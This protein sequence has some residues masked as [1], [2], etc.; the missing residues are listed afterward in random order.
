MV[1]PVPIQQVYSEKEAEDTQV[2]CSYSLR[3]G[4]RKNERFP[5]DD[6]QRE[7][8]VLGGI[9]RKLMGN[10]RRASQWPEIDPVL[11]AS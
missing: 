11:W 3:I 10:L 4:E 6:P 1:V 9:T 8:Y 5:R 2:P 7:I